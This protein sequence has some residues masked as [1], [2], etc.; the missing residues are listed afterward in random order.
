MTNV[1]IPA[2]GLHNVV[3]VA[4]ENDS[5]YAFDADGNE[6]L[7]VKPLWQSS[8]VNSAAGVTAVPSSIYGGSIANPTFGITSTPVIDPTTGTIYVEALTMEVSG[9]ATNFVHRLHALDITTGLER[10]NFNSPVIIICTNYSGAGM[11]DNDGQNLPHVLWNP[12]HL[13][14][15]CALTLLNGAVYVGFASIGDITPYHGW[16]FAY[17]AT[18]LSQRPAVYNSTPNGGQGGFW[19]GGGGPSVDAEGNLFLQ[20]GNGSVDSV[21]NITTTNNYGMTLVKLAT[22][23]GLSLTDF[24]TPSNAVVLSGE[25]QDLGSSAP[26]IL[27]DSAGSAAHPHLV[28][29]G[30]KTPPIYLVDRDSMGRFNGPVG[31]DLIVQ[32]F[33]GGPTGDKDVTPAFFNNT[34]YV[35]DVNSKIGA[36]TIT[37]ALL[38]ST[39]AETPDTYYNKGGA[40][41]S[42]SANGCSNAIVWAIAN[43][44]GDLLT[45]PCVLRAYNATNLNQELYSSDQLPLR[46]S[47]GDAVK[48]T[49]PTIANGKVYVAGQYALT[50]YGLAT[51]FVNTPA[52]S[53]NGSLFT[54]SVTVTLTDTTP[55]AAIYYTLDGTTPTTNSI[56]FNG[57]FVLTNSA[58]VTAEAFASGAKSSGTASASF[59]DTSASANGTG[60]LGQYWADT[61]SSAFI[62]PGFDTT[63]TLTRIDPTIDFDWTVTP[64][65]SDVGLNTF[66]VRWIGTVEARY[67]ETYTFS[68]TTEDGVILRINGQTL[69]NEWMD[70][71]PT[72]W[73][74]SIPML[75]QQRYNIEMDYF[76]DGGS[77]QAHLFWSSPSTGPTTI[78]PESQL[79]PVTNPPPSVVLTAPTNGAALTAVASLTLSADAAAQFNAVSQVAFYTNG[80]LL[81]TVTN[82]PYT[83][84]ATGLQAGGYTLTAVATDTTGL[85][86]TSAPVSITVNAASGLL[87]GLAKYPAAPAFYNMPPVFSGPL[88]TLLSLT[89]V[90]TN[91]PAMAPAA[92]LL[93]YTPNVPL[94]SD[95]AQK[96]RYFSVPNTGAPYTPS[97]QIAYAPTS[98]WSFPSGTVFVKT[99]ELQTNQSDPNSLLRLETR[100]LVCD[101]NGAVY[102]VTYKWRRDYSDA[103]LLSSNLTE[104][105]P[106]V[107]PTG[108][109]RQMWYYPSPSDCL[110]CHTPAANYVLGVNA[111]QL[112]GNM[113]YSNGVTDNQLR[114]INRTGLLYPAIDESSIPGIEQLSSVTNVSASFVQRRDLISTPIVHSA[115]NLAGPDRLST[116]ATTRR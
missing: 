76:Q 102:G 29:G 87:Y 27:P 36:Y 25:D 12:L 100:L 50:V 103:E 59:L 105:I 8:F 48:F 32:Q 2:R 73:S 112:N 47:A 46:D 85:I 96:V 80:Q 113:L 56:L 22:T 98:V 82:L 10:A 1:V 61:T 3:Y 72:T 97:E 17:N 81:G 33:N 41:A 54:N 51:G 14:C 49:V 13:V 34:L 95:G 62:S 66:V 77:A 94:W 38:N 86:T 58:S 55:G 91:T 69:I 4:T 74:G 28:V 35:I 114:A 88:P 75:A 109:T 115:T 6:G 43:S 92:S 84:T 19:Q 68:T 39:P 111:R 57:P 65:A 37:N 9:A 44:G 99:F 83:L 70:Q 106:I 71:P 64:P 11:G 45:T 42:I 93:P 7:N 18:N 89:G 63:P 104:A 79:F 23:N 16:L 40:T 90:F 52:I 78:V 20:T 31:K 26:I 110:Q 24:F 107:T 60:L 53:P 15:R 67:N 101:T 5:L 30:G 108:V 21:T 116:L